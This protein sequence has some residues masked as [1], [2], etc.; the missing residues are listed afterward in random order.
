M[1][2]ETFSNGA[3]DEDTGG[4]TMRVAVYVPFWY[5]GEGS[6]LVCAHRGVFDEVSPWVYGLSPDGAIVPQYAPETAAG[7]EEDLARLR[8]ARLPI[9]PSLANGTAERFYRQPIAGILGDR[10]RRGA[11][12]SAIA[13]LVEREGYAGIDI[14]YEELLAEDREAFTAFLAEL[15]R[16]LHPNGTTLSVALFAKDS[17]A[18]YGAQHAAQ[19]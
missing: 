13:E 12:V 15:A 8:A 17:D 7:I 14:D 2:I 4:A 16:A 9:V 11:H 10:S 19:D 18:G 1:V 6:S 3:S 5:S